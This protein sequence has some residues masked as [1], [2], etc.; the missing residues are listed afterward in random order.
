MIVL[1]LHLENRIRLSFLDDTVYAHGFF[2]RH[3]LFHLPFG[4]FM[5]RLV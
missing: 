3:I 1:E 2:F 5:D 4:G